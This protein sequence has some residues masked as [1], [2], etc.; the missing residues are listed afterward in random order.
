MIKDNKII[1][2]FAFENLRKNINLFYFRLDG[3][4]FYIL[5]YNVRLRTAYTLN[6]WYGKSSDSIFHRAKNQ[7]RRWTFHLKNRD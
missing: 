5:I 6:F 1:I 2:D 7:V 3:D 4:G